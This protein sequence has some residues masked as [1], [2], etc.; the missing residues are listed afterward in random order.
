MALG[1]HDMCI[2]FH[3][4]KERLIEEA[5]KNPHFGTIPRTRERKREPARASESEG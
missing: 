4:K 3:K 5:T 1:E 2:S